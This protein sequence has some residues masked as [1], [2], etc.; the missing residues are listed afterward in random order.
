MNEKEYRI[1]EGVSGSDLAGCRTPLEFYQRKHIHKKVH[2]DYFD[3]GTAAHAY[4]L[5]RE[6]FHKMIVVANEAPEPENLNQD[7]SLNKKGANGTYIKAVKAA[8]PDMI[9]FEPFQYQ[10]VVGYCE[11]V[12]QIPDFGRFINLETGKVEVPYFIEC[13]ETGLMKK[14]RVDYLKTEKFLCDLK[15]AASND[16]FEIAKSF[17]EYEYHLRA[18]YYL[19]LHNETTGEEID[20]FIYVIVS[21]GENPTCRILKLSERDI[22]AGRVIYKERLRTIAECYKTGDWTLNSIENYSLPDWVFN[23]STNF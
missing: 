22:N 3:I 6:K 13:K 4:I 20:T 21:K 23:K 9:V 7:G 10:A 5:E 17:R 16:D 19:D 2:R 12:L 15:F 18:A 1:K 11:S 14:G 8:N